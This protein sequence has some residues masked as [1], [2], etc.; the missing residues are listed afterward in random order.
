MSFQ[1]AYP[2]LFRWSESYGILEIGL[3]PETNSVVRCL[4]EGGTVFES[5]AKITDIEGA[6]KM[7]ED[8]IYDWFEINEPDELD[9]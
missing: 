9:D 1:K 3:Q 7:A 6:L 2:Y 5:P 4:D 8:A